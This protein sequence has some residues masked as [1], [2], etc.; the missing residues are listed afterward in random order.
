M[1]VEKTMAAIIVPWGS[2]LSPVT[3]VRVSGWVDRNI[4][5]YPAIQRW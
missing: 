1:R 2:H 4:F 5:E 3:Y